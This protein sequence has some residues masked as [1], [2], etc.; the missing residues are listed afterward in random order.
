MK[1]G[2]QGCNNPAVGIFCPA[3]AAAKTKT[4]RDRDGDERKDG[5]RR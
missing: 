2:A 1:C 5:K 3:H 4:E